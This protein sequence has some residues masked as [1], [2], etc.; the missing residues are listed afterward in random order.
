MRGDHPAAASRGRVEKPRL[1]RYRWSGQS[2]STALK[3]GPGVRLGSETP[4][5]TQRSLTT[6]AHQ[7]RASRFQKQVF[8]LFSFPFFFF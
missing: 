3:P 4:G 7:L 2:S 6:M 1:E 5:A 8:L